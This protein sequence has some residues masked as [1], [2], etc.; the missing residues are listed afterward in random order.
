MWQLQTDITASG[1]RTGGGGWG[2]TPSPLT[3]EKNINHSFWNLLP[4]FIQRFPKLLS[5][6]PELS[7]SCLLISRNFHCDGII[8]AGKLFWWVALEPTTNSKCKPRQSQGVLLQLESCC[9]VIKRLFSK[10]IMAGQH[11]IPVQKVFLEENGCNAGRMFRLRCH[12]FEL[13]KPASWG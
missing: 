8:P 13:T 2:L 4:F 9:D 1:V 12:N 6:F 10:A 7:N 5:C 11:D 3:I